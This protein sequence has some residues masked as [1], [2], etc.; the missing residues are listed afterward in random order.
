MVL[1]Q[2]IKEHLH[3]IGVHSSVIQVQK[4]KNEKSVENFYPEVSKNIRLRLQ[5]RD[6]NLNPLV[7][8][9]VLQCQMRKIATCFNGILH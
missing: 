6:Q 7:C 3:E 2:S 4:K 1:I 5:K 8:S 9:I